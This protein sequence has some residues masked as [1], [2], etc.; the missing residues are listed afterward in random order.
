MAQ[1]V[2]VH[3]PGTLSIYVATLMLDSHP[4]YTYSSSIFIGIKPTSTN[5]G[6]KYATSDWIWTNSAEWEF[7][8]ESEFFEAELPRLSGLLGNKEI[9]AIDEFALCIQIDNSPKG[10][11]A[12]NIPDRVVMPQSMVE[13]LRSMV[14][15]ITGDV[16]FICLEHANVPIEGEEGKTQIVSRKRV[17]YA[18]S[19]ILKA[20]GEYFKDLL[21]CGF[22]ESE[23]SKKGDARYITILVDDAGFDTVYWMLR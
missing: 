6:H 11:I 7:S 4:D 1:K 23:M 3:D 2:E 19:N 16:R 9:E 13:G 8:K 22:A 20:R 10:Q 5:T 15:S 17:L 14:D 18:H 21:M 12:F